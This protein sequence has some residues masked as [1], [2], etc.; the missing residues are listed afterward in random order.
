MPY[1]GICQE[2]LRAEGHIWFPIARKINS[3]EAQTGTV[4][5]LILY[6]YTKTATP[7]LQDGSACQREASPLLDSGVTSGATW[8]GKTGKK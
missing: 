1:C 3:S 8:I 2:Q 5:A 7:E 4:P 6:S